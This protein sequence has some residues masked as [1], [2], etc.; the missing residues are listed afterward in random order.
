MN[1]KPNY[2]KLPSGPTDY[3]PYGPT[4]KSPY[5]GINYPGTQPTINYANPS[6]NSFGSPVFSSNQFYTSPTYQPGGYMPKPTVTTTTQSF[7]DNYAGKKVYPSFEDKAT[8]I[9]TTFPVKYDP[10]TETVFNGVTITGKTQ[11]VPVKKTTKKNYYNQKIT[12][13]IPIDRTPLIGAKEADLVE[14]DDYFEKHS[15]KFFTPE[16]DEIFLYFTKEYLVGL[17]FC[18]RDSWGREEREIYK[19]NRHMSKSESLKNYFWS[20]MKLDFDDYIKEV[21]A[22]GGSHVTY[23]K[24]ISYKGKVIECGTPSGYELKNLIPDLCKCIG[25][26]GSHGMCISNIYFYYT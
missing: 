15:D 9:T 8:V 6:L 20:S 24:I 7:T 3:T 1:T 12:S 19:G 25:V 22:E 17:Q 10:P 11:T 13:T 26:G 21:Y 16:I 2:T 23:L 14:F 5:T 18:Y 4:T